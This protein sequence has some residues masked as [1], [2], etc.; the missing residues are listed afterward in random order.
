VCVLFYRER[1]RKTEGEREK[2][3]GR[4]KK[5]RNTET[6][7]NK[8]NDKILTVIYGLGVNVSSRALVLQV[9]DLGFNPLYSFFQTSIN[10]KF[11]K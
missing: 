9:Q 11:L 5:K 10:V 4:V 2:T 3:W 6:I 7:R 1:K 8:E